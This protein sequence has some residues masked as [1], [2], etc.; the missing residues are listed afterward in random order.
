M[1]SHKKAAHL[2][3][4]AGAIVS[5]RLNLD[6]F[7]A[8][9]DDEVSTRLLAIK[10]IGGWSVEQILFWHLEWPDV[11]VSGDH[12]FR[13]AL[14][15]AYGLSAFLL[16]DALAAMSAPCW[17]FRSHVAHYLLKS[18]FRPGVSDAWPRSGRPKASRA[19]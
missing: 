10:G 4:L 9:T 2:A 17:P 1:H 14:T 7:D 18:A 8:Y 15:R 12:A 19:P 3:E 13:R 6:D 11:L 5:K 16:P